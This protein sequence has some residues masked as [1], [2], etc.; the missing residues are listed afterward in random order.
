MSNNKK[1]SYKGFVR[2]TSNTL[3]ATN[4]YQVSLP[5]HVWKTKM[6]W[7]LN[8]KVRILTNKADNTITIIKGD[9]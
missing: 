6:G 8:E 7:K 2:S 9:E 4:H 5:P 1:N 3:T